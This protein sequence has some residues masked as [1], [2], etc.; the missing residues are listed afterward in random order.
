MRPGKTALELLVMLRPLVQAAALRRVVPRVACVLAAS[1]VSA[2]LAVALFAV[3]LYAAYLALEQYAQLTPLAAT[4]ALA[5]VVALLLVGCLVVI[6]RMVRRLRPT[7][8]PVEQL[9]RTIDA[10]FDGFKN[11]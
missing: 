9:A 10:F 6:R 11:P 1:V 8:T 3:L 2:A 4:L 5:G 7:A